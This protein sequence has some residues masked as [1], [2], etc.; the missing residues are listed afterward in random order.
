MLLALQQE[1]DP[2]VLKVSSFQSLIKYSIDKDQTI[3]EACSLME[4]HS[5]R[6]LPVTKDNKVVGIIS[7]KDIER[8]YMDMHKKTEF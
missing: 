4:K 7:V 2:K 3:P 6:H 8:Y 1:C 5:V